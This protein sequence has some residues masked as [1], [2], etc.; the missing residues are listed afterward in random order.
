MVYSILGWV[1]ETV[2]CSLPQGK[3]VERGFLTGPY[4]PIYGFGAVFVLALLAPYSRHPA[5]IFIL[6]AIVTSVLEYAVSFIM[7]K[8]FHMRWWDYSQRRFNINGRVCLLNSVLFGILC[9]FLVLFIHPLVVKLIAEIPLN[10]LYIVSAVVL[11]AFLVDCLYSTRATLRLGQHLAKVEAMQAK[12]KADLAEL[13]ETL[14]DFSVKE[15]LSDLKENLDGFRE[16]QNEKF[17]EWLESHDTFSDILEARA[18]WQSEVKDKLEASKEKMEAG[19]SALKKPANYQERRLL[20][21]FPSLSHNKAE[22]DN[23]LKELR[24]KLKVRNHNT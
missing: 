19:L 1:A 18:Q 22:S 10:Y 2:Y 3:L 8:I 21:S 9:L 16:E 5:F 24:A 6:G 13:R 23:V 7:E 11:G 15:E 4:C 14:E 17:R 20:R 12:I